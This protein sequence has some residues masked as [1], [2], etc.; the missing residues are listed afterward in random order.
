MVLEPKLQDAQAKYDLLDDLF[1]VEEKG[2]GEEEE[3]GIVWEGEDEALQEKEDAE[4]R[5][6]DLLEKLRGQKNIL[7]DELSK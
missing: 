1:Q 4:K 5:H 2:E 6:M 3:G 7:N